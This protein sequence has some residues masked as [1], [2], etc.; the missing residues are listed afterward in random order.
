MKARYFTKEDLLQVQEIITSNTKM[1]GVDISKLTDKFVQIFATRETGRGSICV[2]DDDGI[3]HGILKVT[4]S[5]KIPV[6]FVDFGFMK[7]TTD[8][9]LVRQ[10][11]K[12]C[13]AGIDFITNEAEKRGLYD[14]Y[15]VVRDHLD[16]RLDMLVNASPNF[17][18]RYEVS[19]VELLQ[20]GQTSKFSVF[21]YNRMLIGS[22]N[23]KTVV[24]RQAHLKKEYRPQ[25]WTVS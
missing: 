12:A 5:E 15:Y 14:F 2:A 21:D 16:H 24:I 22:Q 20:P 19:N 9:N 3:I 7:H 10:T 17:K 1:H 18:E 8:R 11:I 4:W 6:W 13:A 23:T 25:L